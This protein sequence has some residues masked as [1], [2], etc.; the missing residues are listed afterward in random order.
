MAPLAKKASNNWPPAKPARPPIIAG[1][2]IARHAQVAFGQ[3]ER[4]GGEIVLGDGK[5]GAADQGAAI[6]EFEPDHHRRAG[7]D[8][9]PEFLVNGAAALEAEQARKRLRLGAPGR[10]R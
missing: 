2:R 9:Q 6:E 7:D 8:R 1:Q 10:W 5:E 4:A 3:A